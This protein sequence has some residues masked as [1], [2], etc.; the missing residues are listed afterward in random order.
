MISIPKVVEKYYK[1]ASRI[2]QHNR[3]RQAD[4]DLERTMQVH[5]SSFR[6]HCTLLS[7]IFVDSWLL[8]KQGSS[9]N[10]YISP[11]KFY[12]WLAHGLIENTFNATGI[13]A[14]NETSNNNQGEQSIL[15]R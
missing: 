8:Y 13:N 12:T 7:I 9:Q 1:C 5:D 3:C 14:S 15:S 6:V 11:N 4:V 2:D 10:D